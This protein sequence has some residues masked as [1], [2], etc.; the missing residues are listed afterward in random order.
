MLGRGYGNPGA[1][2]YRK[3][4]LTMSALINEKTNEPIPPHFYWP[5]LDRQAHV[6]P[7]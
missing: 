6:V 3:V 2:V 1:L 4:T 5:E 7:V